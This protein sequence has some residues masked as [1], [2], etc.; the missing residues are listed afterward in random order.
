MSEERK[1]TLLSPSSSNRWMNCTPSSRLTEDM[2]DENSQFA[3]EGTD[4]HTL[5]EHKL[6]MRLNISTDEKDIRPILKFY[7]EEMERCTDEYVDYIMATYED[8]KAK[9]PDTK[10]YIEEHVDFSN[11]IPEGFGTS[12][13]IIVADDMMVIVDLKYGA[14]VVVDAEKNSQFMIY[15][16]GALNIFDSLYD[17]NNVKVVAFQPRRSHISEWVISKDE[18]ISWGENELKPK[19]ELAYKGEGEFKASEWCRFCKARATCKFRAD[20]LIRHDFEKRPETLCEK[21][22]LE[23][24]GKADLIVDYIHDVKEHAENLLLS[25]HK[26]EGWK[27]V[28][29][30]SNRRYSDPIKVAEVVSNAGYDP[31]EKTVLNITNMTKLLGKTKFET[32]LK[33]YLVKPEGKPTMVPESDARPEIN[34]PNDDFGKIS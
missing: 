15:A 5:A 27:L 6:R 25:G 18:L 26:L 29:G 17:I 9:C 32:L 22:F 30:R 3:L 2:E 1:H 24:L 23:I 7:N 4:A 10:I 13:C 33:P 28:E 14:G 20:Y 19:A 21:E 12:D 34:N 11:Y 31:Y 8:L 16:L